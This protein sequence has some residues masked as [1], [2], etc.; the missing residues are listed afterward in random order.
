MSE[1]ILITGGAGFIGSHLCHVFVK[2]NHEVYCLDNF[3]P[4]YDPSLKRQNIASLLNKKNFHLIE[5]DILDGNLV[6]K[7]IINNSIDYIFHEAA[8]AGV[9]YSI[10]DPIKSNRVNVIGTLNILQACL[11]SSV[12]KIIFGSSSSVY[13]TVHYLPFDEGHPK[14][15]ESPYGVSKL[16]AEH[17]FRVFYE[18]HGLNYVTLRYFTVFGP[19]MRPDLA[20]S[21]FTDSA[22]KNRDIEIF[23]DGKKT[24]DFTYIDNIIDGNILA[25]KKGIGEFNIGGGQRFSILELAQKIIKL[26]NSI[27]KIKFLHNVKGDVYHTSANIEK[28]KKELGYL[29]KISFDE[30]LKIYINYFKSQIIKR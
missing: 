17:L 27:S 3:D 25:M 16:A 4:Y 19:K 5:G 8:Q 22:L 11:D 13:G 20:I 29:P 12:K 28:A 2:K 9:R 26:T 14:T 10:K 6:K 24:R 18:I 7:I 1:N 21:I 30:G 15:P 23:G